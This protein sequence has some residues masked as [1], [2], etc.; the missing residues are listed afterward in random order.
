MSTPGFGVLVLCITGGVGVNAAPHTNFSRGQGRPFVF[1]PLK[2]SAGR[3]FP[4]CTQ[5]TH[6]C[7]FVAH[8]DECAHRGNSAALT[9]PAVMQKVRGRHD[10]HLKPLSS[11]ISPVL[12]PL[13]SSCTEKFFSPKISVSSRPPTLLHTRSP[14][15]TNLPATLF[16]PQAPPKSLSWL[17]THGL[18]PCKTA[19]T[20]SDTIRRPACTAPFLTPSSYHGTNCPAFSCHTS[21]IQ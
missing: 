14:C 21:C 20:M 8:L 19:T 6:L 7:S 1:T 15:C 16:P 12:P 9:G 2:R 11:R 4:P 3:T 18:R 10:P 5:H 13:R 17:G